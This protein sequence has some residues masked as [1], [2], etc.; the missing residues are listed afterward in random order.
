MHHRFAVAAFVL[1]GM[2]MGCGGES[3][4]DQ[5]VEPLRKGRFE[6]TMEATSQSR[7]VSLRASGSFDFERDRY[8]LVTTASGFGP[9]LDG[10]TAIVAIPDAVFVDCPSL[11]RMLGAPTKWVMVRGPAG[12]LFRSSI[13]D[14]LVRPNS[15]RFSDSTEEGGARLSIEYFDV[16]APVA[17]EPPAADELTDETDAVDHLFGGRTGG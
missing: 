1:A 10:T 5:P 12:D 4:P 3:R 2:A 9:G 16:G 15:M 11:T 6:M 13:L 17:I 8:S 14:Q 7:T